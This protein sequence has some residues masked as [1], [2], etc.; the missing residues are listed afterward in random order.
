M[1]PA[2]HMRRR[3][4]PSK[5]NAGRRFTAKRNRLIQKKLLVSAFTLTSGG[6]HS[7]AATAT[8]TNTAMGAVPP[9]DTTP[10]ANTATDTDT[11][12][13][14]ADLAITKTNTITSVVPGTPDT[15]IIVVSNAGPSAVTGAGVSDPL[16][17]GVTA[18][19]WTATASSDTTAAM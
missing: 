13:P 8:L 5:G 2:S 10:A 15:Y 14:R 9:G 4:P 6:A 1:R 12:T 19:T 18:A 16:P 3:R 17:A 11:L 7:A